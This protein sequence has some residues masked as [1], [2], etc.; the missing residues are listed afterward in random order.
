MN[1]Y[2]LT[3]DEATGYDTFDSCI[4][5]AK[6]EEEARGI[7]PSW[8]GEFKDGATWTDWASSP[9]KVEAKLIGV[10]TEGTHSGVILASYNAG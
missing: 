7:S 8:N 4:V 9:E 5:A 2:L 3:Q 6:N 10:A 1:L